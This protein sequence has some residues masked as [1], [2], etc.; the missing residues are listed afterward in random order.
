MDGGATS[1]AA[2]RQITSS[3]R[4]VGELGQGGMGHVW[5]ADHLA[6]RTQ[7]AVKVLAERSIA[8]PGAVARFS[9]EAAAAARIRSPHVVQVFD[10][11][12][13][14]GKPYIVMELLEG[15][16]L[17][18]RL[19]REHPL[20]VGETIAIVRQICKAL[21]KAHAMGIVHRD[22]KPANVFLVSGMGET[23]VKVL[24]FGLAKHEDE[25]L[26]GLTESNAVFGTPH[27]VSPEQAQ[28]AH[29]ATSQSDLWSVA[30]VA[31]EC[32]TGERP[33]PSQSLMGLF[34]ALNTGRFV[35]ATTVRPDLPAAIDAWFT[36]AFQRNPAERFPSALALAEAFAAA[37][38]GDAAAATAGMADT[39]ARPVTAVTGRTSWSQTLSASRAAR[40]AWR[41][42]LGLVGVALLAWIA[43]RSA[44]PPAAEPQAPPAA[45]ALSPPRDPS[46]PPSEATTTTEAPRAAA[47]SSSAAPPPAASAPAQRA[48]S[49]AARA[50][51]AA[52]R[53]R[54][55]ATPAAPADDLFTDPKH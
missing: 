38:S 18:R 6:L 21:D 44:Q 3:L 7:V 13:A 8:V 15:E 46:P 24:D 30:V 37:L 48:V 55:S 45:V 22:I 40:G 43:V 23:F 20:P 29:A 32:L 12:L 36:R 53:P 19:E 47:P 41:V 35:A 9:S 5:V 31:Y 4:L 49:S 50:P 10:H 11:G 51:V 34:L 27:Y 33:F 39:G 42:T 14:D 25:A 54:S 28:N 16:D 1:F 2:G 52:A 26:S 17:A